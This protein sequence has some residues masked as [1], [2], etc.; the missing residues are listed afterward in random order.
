MGFLCGSMMSLW[1][2][3]PF[4]KIRIIKNI[5]KI[6]PDSTYKAAFKTILKPTILLGIAG[7]AYNAT[8]SILAKSRNISDW[9]NKLAAGSLTGFIMSLYKISVKSSVILTISCGAFAVFID[10]CGGNAF[11]PKDQRALDK[12]I[13]K[14]S[15]KEQ[16]SN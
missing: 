11:A 13:Y 15:Q 16:G 1:S 3:M 12:R 6:G 14:P 5:K 4:Q 8:D 7:C 2:G 9:K 10:K